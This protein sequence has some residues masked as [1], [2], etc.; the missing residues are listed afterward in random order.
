MGPPPTPAPA[1]APAPPP[2]QPRPRSPERPAPAQIIA[3]VRRSNRQRQ[4]AD[5]NRDYQRVL[6]EEAARKAQ[7]HDVREPEPDAETPDFQEEVPDIPGAF[8]A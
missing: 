6:D 4:P 3:G 1:P 5:R 7:R 8:S 2:I